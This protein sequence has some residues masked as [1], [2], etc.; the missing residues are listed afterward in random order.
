MNIFVRFAGNVRHV[1]GLAGRATD[2]SFP[3]K[4]KGFYGA[5]QGAYPTP[6]N[7]GEELLPALRLALMFEAKRAKELRQSKLA[8]AIEAD[9]RGVTHQMMALHQLKVN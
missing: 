4:G 1:M 8:A 7:V 6:I 9:L 2:E 5:A 3:R